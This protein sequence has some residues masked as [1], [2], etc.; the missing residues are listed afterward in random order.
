MQRVS[1]PTT[2]QAPEEARELLA[3]IEKKA[4]SV[5]HFVRTMSHRPEIMKAFLPLYSAITGRGAVDRK[6]KEYVYL[7][8][9]IINR[10][11]Y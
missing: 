7:R 10:C 5:T 11:D 9:S 8:T 6:I 3:G 2:E 1:M 4:G